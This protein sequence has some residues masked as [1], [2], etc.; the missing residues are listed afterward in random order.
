MSTAE[1]SF[2]QGPREPWSVAF[3]EP[4][5]ESEAQLRI[6]QLES[7]GFSSDRRRSSILR[8]WVKARRHAENVLKQERAAARRAGH[9]LPPRRVPLPIPDAQLLL[10]EAYA[11]LK[12]LWMAGAPLDAEEVA[13]LAR[14]RAQLHAARPG[15]A[16]P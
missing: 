9:V 3:P 2:T 16:T 14:I 1:S 10:S 15:K 11:A 12:R 5:N 7:R 4:R 13:L 6:A 8:A